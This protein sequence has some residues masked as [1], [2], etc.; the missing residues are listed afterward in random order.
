MG[1]VG[2]Q[3]PETCGLHPE[4]PPFPARR[5]PRL[6]NSFLQPPPQVLL[7][8]PGLSLGSQVQPRPLRGPG[9]P[10]SPLRRPLTQ[11][12]H[13]RPLL[14]FVD[15][16][17]PIAAAQ[18]ARVAEADLVTVGGRGWASPGQVALRAAEAGV[19]SFHARQLGAQTV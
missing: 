9:P 10:L 3:S 19:A 5:A 7:S 1:G 16:Q 14:T 2:R 17:A 13:S 15:A 6:T 11:V 8:A 12:S 18:L 4:A